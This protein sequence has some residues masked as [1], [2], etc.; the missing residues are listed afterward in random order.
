MILRLPLLLLPLLLASSH[1]AVAQARIEP[2]AIEVEGKRTELAPADADAFQRRLN[3]PSQLEAPPSATPPSFPVTTTYWDSAV[4]KDDGEAAIGEKAE[5]FP[6]GGFVRARQDG[7]DVW[8]VL[9][10]RQRATLD[11]YIRFSIEERPQDLRPGALEVVRFASKMESVGL[12]AG[13]RRLS[14]SESQSF[15]EAFDTLAPPPSFNHPAEPPASAEASGYWLT[16]SLPEGRTQQYFLDTTTGVLTDSLGAESYDMSGL[17]GG[18]LPGSEA[19]LP[20]EQQEPA[21]S[22]L[23]WLLAAGGG[24]G[25][26]A[27][28]V[29]LRRWNPVRL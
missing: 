5:Y 18:A 28:A 4:D 29:W 3:L 1:I 9:D 11:R 8:L 16:V 13:N 26:L 23:W 7:L 20:L 22:P 17:V 6:T 25:L 24:I 14:E 21:G 12:E 15:W 2:V 19:A 27:S 10:L